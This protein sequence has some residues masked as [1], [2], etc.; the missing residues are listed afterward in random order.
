MDA[1]KGKPKEELLREE[2]RFYVDQ[3]QKLTQW[4]VTVMVSL[5]TA[6]FFIRRELIDTYVAAGILHKGESLPWARYLVGTSFLAFA[7]FI[8]SLFTARAAV[9]YRHYKEQLVKGSA[10]GIIDK[11]TSGVTNWVI[12]LYFAFPVIDVL[13]RIYITV[14]ISI[15]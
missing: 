10:S 14:T 3:L 7:A 15:R 8:V 5:Q 12:Y 13:I 1:P 11:P 9:Q 2:V 6:L 4:G